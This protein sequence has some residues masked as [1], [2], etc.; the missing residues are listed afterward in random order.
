MRKRLLL[1][2]AIVTNTVWCFAQGLDFNFQSSNQQIIEEVVTKG[3]YLIKQEYILKDTTALNPKSYG[4]MGNSFFSISYGLGIIMDSMIITDQKILTPWLNDRNYDEFKNDKTKKPELSKQYYRKL[5][6]T[7][8]TLKPQSDIFRYDSLVP[9]YQLYDST[10]AKGFSL[11]PLL[12]EKEGWVVAVSTDKINIDSLTT[13]QVDVYK[14]KCEYSKN[15]LPIEIKKLPVNKRL[16][17]GFFIVPN[18]HTIGSVCFSV[19][20]YISEADDKWYV[21]PIYV[22]DKVIDSLTPIN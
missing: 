12:G 6:Q 2:V 10:F 5:D 20:G 9:V 14:N 18:Y 15:R 17:G 1:L 19:A 22:K 21:V 7:R 16:I 4:R 13:F 3:L 8:Y 11:D